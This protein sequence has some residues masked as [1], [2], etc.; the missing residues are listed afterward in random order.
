MLDSIPTKRV[1]E[2][3]LESASPALLRRRAIATGID[4]AVCYF[5]IETAILAALLVAFT[6]AFLALGNG[7]LL[8]SV[9]GLVP[10]YLGY[11]FCF[12]WRYGR[13]PGK[14]RMGLLV[15]GED[16]AHLSVHAAAIRNVLRYVDWLPVGY[17]LGWFFVR[18]SPTGRRLGDHLAGT[19]VVRPVTTAESLYDRDTHARSTS[20]SSDGQ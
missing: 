6:D 11:T 19:V 9:V 7:A 18:R 1:P 3:D 4:L 12:E 2:P 13:T 17:V 10:I 8:L 16:G 14:K 15:V 20:G 5:V